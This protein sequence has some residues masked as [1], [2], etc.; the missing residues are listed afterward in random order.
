M[1]FPFFFS[2][3]QLKKELNAEKF[4]NEVLSRYKKLFLFY[5]KSYILFQNIVTVLLFACKLALV[6]LFTG[7]YSFEFQGKA[8]NGNLKENK[9]IL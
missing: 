9:K 1:T 7:K 6:A 2:Q 8:S 5:K 4:K 3:A